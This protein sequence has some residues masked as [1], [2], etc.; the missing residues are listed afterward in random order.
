MGR[1][2]PFGFRLWIKLRQYVIAAM[3]KLE[4]L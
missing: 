2:N 4:L 3:A 1:S